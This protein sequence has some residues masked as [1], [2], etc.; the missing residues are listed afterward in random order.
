MLRAAGHS[1]HCA[2]SLLCVLQ[3][4]NFGLKSGDTNSEGEWWNGRS[5]ERKYPLPHQTLG[6]GE[7]HELSHRG[8]GRSPCR[9]WF[10]CNLISAD[11]FCWQQVTANSSPFRPEKRGYCTRQSKKRRYRYPSI[12]YPINY[13]YGV[14]CIT[15]TTLIVMVL[16]VMY[17]RSFEDCNEFVVK[18]KALGHFIFRW[19]QSLKTLV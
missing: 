8:T 4:R 16:I 13:A 17:T 9:K 5:M 14:L 6:L 7:H 15:R 19:D 1:T 11:R 18:N 12:V 10:Y 2:S 3:G